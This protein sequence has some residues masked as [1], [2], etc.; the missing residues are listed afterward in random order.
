VLSRVGLPEAPCIRC[1]RRV[2]GLPW[3]ERCAECTAELRRRAGTIGGRA[4]LAATVIAAAYVALRLP[5]DPAARYYGVLAIV[6]TYVLVR[7]IVQRIMMEVL[8]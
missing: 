3:G 4:A 6:V 2:A 1:G 7:R 5:A 8:Q